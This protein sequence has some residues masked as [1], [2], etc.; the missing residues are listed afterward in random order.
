MENPTPTQVPEHLLNQPSVIKSFPSR[1]SLHLHP[2]HLLL[3]SRGKVYFPSAPLP[4]PFKFCTPLHYFLSFSWECANVFC[5]CIFLRPLE[6]LIIKGRLM[7]S[8]SS[9]ASAGPPEP[10]PQQHYG[11]LCL[12]LL[13]PLPLMPEYH[14]LFFVFVFLSI[15]NANFLKWSRTLMFYLFSFFIF[16]LLS[17]PLPHP[18]SSS[19]RCLSF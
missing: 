4:L 13:W 19:S 14:L 8:L 15:Q 10:R 11:F 2:E 12:G 16:P 3:K 18:C 5:L 9:G 6:C 7:L 1:S 17:P